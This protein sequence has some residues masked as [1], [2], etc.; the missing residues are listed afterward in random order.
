MNEKKSKVTVEIFGESYA[1]KGDAEAE[2]IVKVAAFVDERMHKIAQANVRL[3]P[4]KIAVLAALNIADECL[5][6][7]KDY[8]ELLELLKDEK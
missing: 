4:A 2:R 8:Q 7:E 3:S 5:Q 6:L 1:L